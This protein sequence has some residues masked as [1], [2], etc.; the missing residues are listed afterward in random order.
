MIQ[1]TKSDPEFVDEQSL[2]YIVQAA[3]L[4]EF[5]FVFSL[6]YIIWK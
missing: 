5:Y 6:Y 2:P 1:I 4:S 3:Q